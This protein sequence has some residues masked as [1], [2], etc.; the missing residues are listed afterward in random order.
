MGNDGAYHVPALLS[1]AVDGL[2][3]RENGA[4]LDG[5]LGGGGHFQQIIHRLVHGTAIGIDRDPSAISWCTSHIDRGA[6]NTILAHTRFSQFDTILADNGI[7]A[8]DG[9][10]LDLGV[11]SHQIDS[12]ERGFS[13]QQDT[14]LDMRM[15]GNDGPDAATLIRKGDVKTISDI[16]ANFGEIQNPLRMARVIAAAATQ[17]GVTTSADLRACLIKEYGPNLRIKVLAKVFQALRIAVN[18]ELEELAL[19]LEKIPAWLRTGGRLV[20]ISYHSLEDRMVKEFMH[21]QERG[22][23]CPKE[24]PVCICGKAPLFKRI[25]KKVITAPENEIHNNRRARSARLRISEKI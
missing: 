9:A 13:Y 1:E 17:G 10:L 25:N 15:G 23:V 12:N 14:A 8:V 16:L 4:Y 24:V 2:A 22:C 6:V 3:I 5:T 7:D 11:S 19:F 21:R 20:V 18:H